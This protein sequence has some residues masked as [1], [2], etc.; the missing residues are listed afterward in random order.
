[1]AS[2]R[3][4]LAATAALAALF[5]LYVGGGEFVPTNDCKAVVFAPVVLLSSHSFV[6]TPHNAPFMFSWRLRTDERAVS[7][8]H[9]AW[10]Y[11]D[12][13]PPRAELERAGRLSVG[14]ERYY[15]SPTRVAG[16]YLNNYGPLPGLM[17][18]PAFALLHA[19]FGDLRLHPEL[20]WQGAKA[21]V[22]L[23]TVL[24][25]ALLFATAKQWAPPA[26]AGLVALT[27]A[28]G[29]MAWPVASQ[30]PCQQS[31]GLFW[32]ALGL[33]AA[34]RAPRSARS[35]ALCGLALGLAAA[36]R[37]PLGWYGLAMGAWLLWPAARATLGGARLPEQARTAWPP[38]L[39]YSAAGAAPIALVLAYNLYF[40]GNASGFGQVQ[41]AAGISGDP[42][43]TP[44]LYGAWALLASPSRGL[45]VY[46]PVLG[47]ALLGAVRALREPR[48]AALRPLAVGA[49]LIFLTYAKWTSW[50]GGWSYGPRL[51]LDIAPVACLLLLP[52]WEWLA[53]RSLWRVCFGLALVWSVFTAAVGAT[54]YDLLGWNAREAY[55]VEDPS[56]GATSVLA[57]ATDARAQAAAL[58]TAIKGIRMDVDSPHFHERLM[59]WSDSPLVYYTTHFAQARAL[60]KTVMRLAIE[61]PAR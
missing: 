49:L 15:L 13:V 42:W 32:L 5:V 30:T 54:A 61:D 46:S 19:A 48:W 8:P 10:R 59:S 55:A 23:L 45:L 43:Q 20:I 36:V 56:T 39:A 24:G 9:R 6:F 28:L 29:T 17:L 52:A 14:R 22:A 1:M 50:W 16:E 38:A 51:L 60:R 2:R 21:V 47:F 4:M 34:P 18:L 58:H 33:W 31:F 37:A 11:E 53:T 35:A 57:D 44:L 12:G 3:Q 26:Q 7:L 40:F 41:R 25:T 27:F